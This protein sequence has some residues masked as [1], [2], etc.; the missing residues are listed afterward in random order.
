MDA[1]TRIV[2]VILPNGETLLVETEARQTLE[3]T[4]F[5]AAKFEGVIDAIEGIAL[6][7]QSALAK[8]KPSKA[9]VELGLEIGVEAGQL[10]ALLVKGTGKANLKITLQWEYSP[11]IASV[12]RS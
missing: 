8:V 9:S 6:G 7:V 1:E 3:S 12:G 5:A 10:T 4:G 11:N 2:S